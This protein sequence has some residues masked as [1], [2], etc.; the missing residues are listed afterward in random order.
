MLRK[1]GKAQNQLQQSNFTVHTS[2][3]TTVISNKSWF[4]S[5]LIEER[6]ADALRETSCEKM[7]KIT[8]SFAMRCNESV[9]LF[10]SPPSLTVTS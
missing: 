8:M 2:S 4:G 6:N 1:F 5:V 3:K 9:F 7:R 10:S